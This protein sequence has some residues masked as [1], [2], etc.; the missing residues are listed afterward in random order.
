MTVQ[1]PVEVPGAI[2]TS[3][4]IMWLA[5][6]ASV[7]TTMTG[8]LSGAATGP[9]PSPR[10][11]NTLTVKVCTTPTSFTAFG[12]T[13]SVD[14]VKETP[15]TSSIT[16]AWPVTSPA[17]FDV[18]T[19]VHWPRLSRL[20]P[21]SSHVLAPAF[22]EED[23]PFESVRVKLTWPTIAGTKPAPSPE[24][25]STATVN[26]CSVPTSFAADGPIVM[27]ASTKTF[28][29]GPELGAMP[30]VFTWTV[31]PAMMTSASALP[32]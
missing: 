1:A 7:N 20:S 21:A 12:E 28:V 17:S 5:P 24:F 15:R 25:A 8:V 6:P 2:H 27:D 16:D 13:P 23:A 31:F 9:R 11:T 19:I 22:N 4:S 30:S 10:S 32:V 26:V 29:A 18:K 14:R 3:D